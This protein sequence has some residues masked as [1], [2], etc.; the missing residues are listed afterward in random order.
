[1]YIILSG[2]WYLA[3]DERWQPYAASLASLSSSFVVL[4]LAIRLDS[5]DS[6]TAIVHIIPTYL[7]PA[8]CCLIPVDIVL[9]PLG[10]LLAELLATCDV[11][12]VR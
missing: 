5:C 8:T 11:L 12:E 10:P 3:F 9:H 4:T 7:A 1:M 2:W 6:R